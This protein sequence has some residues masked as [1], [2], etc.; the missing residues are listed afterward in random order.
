MKYL[1]HLFRMSRLVY[2]ERGWMGLLRRMR[3]F[4]LDSLGI[5]PAIF[6]G[7]VLYISGCPGGSRLYRCTNQSEM[8]EQHG[9]RS[10]V[11]SQNVPFLPFL[12]SRYDIFIL[13]RVI[14]NEYIDDVIKKIQEQGKLIFFETD[15]L[16]FDPQYLSFMHFYYYMGD[17]EKKWYENGIGR[18]ILENPYVAHC[19][20]STDFLSD[21]LTK[22]YPGKFIFVSQNVLSK[23][24][25]AT[26]EKVFLQKEF[27]R[28]SDKKIRIGYFSGS[29]SH[30]K[31]FQVVADTL[32][33][34]LKENENVMLSI[35]G[36][37][38]LSYKFDVVQKQ[39]ERHPFVSM[40]DLYGLIARVDINIAPLEIDNMFC[41]G[42]SAIKFFE[43]GL[44]SVPTIAS[45]TTSFAR[46][47]KNEENGFL[48]SC[49]DDWKKYLDKLLNDAVAREKIGEQARRDVLKHFVTTTKNDEAFL[50]VLFIQSWLKKNRYSE[51]I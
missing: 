26:A 2:R 13:Q 11:I 5:F 44:L 41:Q 35:V 29:K 25:V 37:L 47:I 6:G 12:I 18:E 3:Q 39:I 19:I 38:H 20:V 17:E 22:K 10:N 15:D 32:L 16:V 34:F 27:Y 14:H 46:V 42:K 48:A 7:D 43:A 21:I 23:N 50:L 28:P 30:D 36:P 1:R 33:S 45:R 4:L 31:D 40:K 9:I 8:L 51:M 49:D 24:Q